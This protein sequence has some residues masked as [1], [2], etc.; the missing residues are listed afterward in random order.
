MGMKLAR[1]ADSP[2]STAL[3]NF[4]ILGKFLK[5]HCSS[6]AIMMYFTQIYLATLNISVVFQ[7]YN[8]Y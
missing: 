1:H 5:R 3:F 8:F 7:D 4:K 6:L 2:D